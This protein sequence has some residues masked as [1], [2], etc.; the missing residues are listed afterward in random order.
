M[1]CFRVHC[2][3]QASDPRG[4]DWVTQP[5]LGG[6]P[7]QLGPSPAGD[8]QC[9]AA[10]SASVHNTG[11]G[12]ELEPKELKGAETDPTQAKVKLE[13][14]KAPWPRCV[15]SWSHCCCRL[16]APPMPRLLRSR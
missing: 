14:A 8:P 16:S 11:A 1:G 7:L 5:S 2:G 6:C 12:P 10:M 3:A 13:Q 9:G 15:A 4:E